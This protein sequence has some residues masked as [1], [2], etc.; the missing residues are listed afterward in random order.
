MIMKY[1][2]ILNEKIRGQSEREFV[3]SELNNTFTMVTK[4]TLFVK[5]RRKEYEIKYKIEHCEHISKDK[6]EKI[7]N[8]WFEFYH[9]DK[10]REAEVLLHANSLLTSNFKNSKHALILAYDESSEF[11]SNKI[12]PKLHKFERLIRHLIFLVLVKAFGS[13]W[14]RST[15]EKELCKKLNTRIKNNYPKITNANKEKKLIEDALY[16]IYLSELEVFL[17]EKRPSINLS[18]L[19]DSVLSTEALKTMTKDDIISKI[20]RGRS[21]SIWDKFFASKINIENLNLKIPE[22]RILRNKVAHSKYFNLEDYKKA[23]ELTD[24]FISTF[25]ESIQTIETKDYSNQE[26]HDVLSSLTHMLSESISVWNFYRDTI[27][28]EIKMLADISSSRLEILN[29]DRILKFFDTHNIYNISEEV[30]ERKNKMA[31][32]YKDML[33]PSS[34][35]KNLIDDH[36]NILKSIGFVNHFRYLNFELPVLS[37]TQKFIATILKNKNKEELNDK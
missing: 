26:I 35:Y 2:L 28:P 9:T 3:E 13:S 1:L 27:S 34:I 36:Q 37:Q 30:I 20:E 17:F 18:E 19:I 10:M 25:Q 14:A 21:K 24:L 33:P 31:S 4:E 7:F 8:I 6:K 32:V 12:F 22:L 5:P 15:L 23:D 16:E 29:Y 11:L